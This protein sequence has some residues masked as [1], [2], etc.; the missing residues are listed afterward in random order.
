MAPKA[1]GLESV[2]ADFREAWSGSPSG[3]EDVIHRDQVKVQIGYE[4]F[5]PIPTRV[6]RT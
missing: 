1:S 4:L 5:T 3:S 2:A 6:A